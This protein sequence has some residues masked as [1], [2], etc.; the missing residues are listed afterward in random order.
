MNNTRCNRS[1]SADTLLSST[2]Q[3]EIRN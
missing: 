1:T 3:H 2:V